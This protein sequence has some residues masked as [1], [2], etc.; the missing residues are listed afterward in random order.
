MTRNLCQR[1]RGLCNK[2]FL[3]YAKSGLPRENLFLNP[4]IAAWK[5]IFQ[6]NFDFERPYFVQTVASVCII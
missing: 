5:D 2:V 6:G 3:Q 4:K 1:K